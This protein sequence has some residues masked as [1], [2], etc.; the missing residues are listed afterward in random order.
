VAENLD[1]FR[2]RPAGQF[3]GGAATA[4]WF[5][6]FVWGLGLGTGR[7]GRVAGFLVAGTLT[8]SMMTQHLPNGFF[9]NWFN[10]QRGEGMEFNLLGIALC[11]VVIWNGSGAL[12]VDRLLGSREPV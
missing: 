11:L 6:E 8:V 9:M 3:P 5:C 7:L 2:R 10:T 1:L 4:A 12:S